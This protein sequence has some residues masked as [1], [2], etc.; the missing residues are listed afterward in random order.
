MGESTLLHPAVAAGLGIPRIAPFPA[1]EHTWA[2]R[3][4]APHSSRRSPRCS[5]S[6]LQRRSFARRP[7]DAGPIHRLAIPLASPPAIAGTHPGAVPP[8]RAG[9]GR[10]R[11]RA[12]GT[13]VA[14]PGTRGPAGARPASRRRPS[15]CNM[16]AA[17]GGERARLPTPAAPGCSGQG[18]D[19]GL[20]G[21]GCGAAGRRERGRAAGGRCPAGSDRGLTHTPT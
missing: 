17:G 15:L 16:C 3:E 4:A 18:R 2:A 19:P 7:R 1:G 21:R 13:A 5:P 9:E 11:A 20:A 8:W 10:R 6:P 12:A 14:A